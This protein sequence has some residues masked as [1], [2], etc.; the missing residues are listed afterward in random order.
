MKILLVRTIAIEEDCSISTYNN[1]GIGLASELI[2][3]GHQCDLV[4]YAKKG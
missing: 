1:Q 3:L 2:K 4:Y